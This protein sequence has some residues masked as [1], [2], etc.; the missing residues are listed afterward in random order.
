MEL[1]RRGLMGH[2]AAPLL[3]QRRGGTPPPNIVLVLADGLPA[4]V[5][6]CYGN[7]EIR[8]PHIDRLAAAGT[9]MALCFTPAPAGPPGRAS[10]F[11]GRPPAR[12]GVTAAPAGGE[13]DEGQAPPSFA[14]ER[15]L[16]DVLAAA[17]YRCG[18]V[19]LWGMGAAERPGHGFEFAAVLRRPV[20][21]NPDFII[22]GSPV[23]AKG[24]LAEIL[25]KYAGDFL[26]RQQKE[27]PFFL[28]ISH[29]SPGGPPEGHPASFLNQY[30]DARFADFGI[31]PAAANAVQGREFLDNPLPALRRYAA[32]VSALDEQVGALHRRILELGL[33][34]NTLF[35]FTS[36]HGA[37]LGRHGLWG[38]GRASRPAN[39]YEEVIH[40]PMIWSWPGRVPTHNVRP[41]LVSLYDLL[42]AV[43][44]AAGAGASRELQVCSRSFLP[45]VMNRPLPKKN[46]W[47]DI[48]FAQ[49]EDAVMARDKYYKLIVR[50]D[51][52]GELYDIRK[53]PRERNNVF[54]DPGFSTV[55][56]VLEK[57]LE[58]WRASCG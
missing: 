52:R 54:S 49:L 12:H 9:R 13:A 1:T 3:M 11:S 4:W 40:V 57:K 26:A 8:T 23:S 30:A 7:E 18:F 37:L 21:E 16:S 55:R 14:K 56:A 47:P 51:G 48:V 58:A 25:T 19:G 15:L 27:K 38:D 22:D 43:G 35:V 20:H 42:P 46:P 32:A 39:L 29:L 45:L 10:L 50:G 17:G 31:M 33:F 6:G 36:S 34:D 53:D 28:A 2:L 44:E 24:Y 5:L 41:E